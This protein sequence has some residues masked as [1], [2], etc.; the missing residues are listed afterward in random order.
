NH[1]F[2]IVWHTK[3]G[4]PEIFPTIATIVSQFKLWECHQC[5]DAVKQWCHTNGIPGY[6]LQLKTQY[7]FEDYNVGSF[8]Q[9]DTDMQFF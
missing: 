5:A 3:Y 7:D 1:Y 6:K 9:I 4:R 2:V 8:F